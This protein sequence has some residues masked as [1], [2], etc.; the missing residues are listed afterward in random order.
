MYDYNNKDKTIQEGLNDWYLTQS[1][2]N[3]LN[4][5][6]THPYTESKVWKTLRS[7]WEEIK[8]THS[9]RGKSKYHK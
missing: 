7:I 5:L 4:P 1:T 2:S 9:V 8:P 6:R 3:Q